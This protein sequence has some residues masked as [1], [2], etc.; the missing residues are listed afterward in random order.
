MQE[1]KNL[2]KLAK[3]VTN[4]VEKVGEKAKRTLSKTNLNAKEGH[5][6]PTLPN[7]MSVKDLEGGG[8]IY[9]GV[10]TKYVGGGFSGGG[11]GGGGGSFRRMG[12]GKSHKNRDPG[13]QSDDEEDDMFKFDQLSHRSSGSSLNV[14][15]GMGLVS[16]TSTPMSGSLEKIAEVV[17]DGVERPT[18]LLRRTFGTPMNARKE[19]ELTPQSTP[20][21]SRSM[22]IDAGVARKTSF[23]SSPNEPVLDEWE[24]KLLGKRSAVPYRANHDDAVS[25]HSQFSMDDKTNSL[26][27][28]GQDPERQKA[29][30]IPEVRNLFFFD[31]LSLVS[32]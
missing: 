29:M 20:R 18:D 22:M 32:T 28:I 15:G 1:K 3:S 19:K 30:A 25:Q 27:R 31:V 10:T 17:R 16:K 14:T 12:S 5:V 13:V 4:K 7:K 6:D 2:K 21:S 26:K 24:A 8:D 11:G 9:P 23:T